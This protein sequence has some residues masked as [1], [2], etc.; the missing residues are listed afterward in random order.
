MKGCT[1]DVDG[2]EDGRVMRPPIRVSPPTFLERHFL[3]ELLLLVAVVSWRQRGLPVR[4]ASRR[5]R[6]GQGGWAAVVRGAW[7]PCG[8]YE[9][10]KDVTEGSAWLRLPSRGHFTEATPVASN[11][12]ARQNTGCR[13]AAPLPACQG[14]AATARPPAAPPVISTPDLITI[15]RCARRPSPSRALSGLR[16]AQVVL[17]EGCRARH[18]VAAL[19]RLLVAHL[20]PGV[21][22]QEKGTLAAG[23]RA[24]FWR[25]WLRTAGR[26]PPA[27]H[28]PLGGTIWPTPR[29][30]AADPTDSRLYPPLYANLIPDLSHYLYHYFVHND[31]HGGRAGERGV[32]I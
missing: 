26:R 1:A 14:G 18:S 23:F 9:A 30:P 10:V 25:L 5:R 31:T 8:L 2:R 20:T 3:Y 28:A 7:R 11:K 22:A 29:H 12:H 32:I 4:E 21:G 13:A 24:L 6:G 16:E 19:Y 27:A 17:S 15:W